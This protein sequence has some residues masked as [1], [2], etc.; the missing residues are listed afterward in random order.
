MEFKT[1]SIVIPV[2]NEENLIV[3]ALQRVVEADTCGLKKEII[4]INDGSTD[5]TLS[6]VKS[7][8]SKVKSASKNLKIILI[9]KEKNQ[10][11]GAADEI[12]TR[13]LLLGR[14]TFYR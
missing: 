3:K 6:K 1:I 9:N 2:Y 10:G 12:R 11:K 5:K 4:I 8:M 14:E 7:Q 13:D